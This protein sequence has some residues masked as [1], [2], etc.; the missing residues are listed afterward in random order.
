MKLKIRA[1]E[2]R[3]RRLMAGLSQE[4]LAEKTEGVVSASAISKLE[5]LGG[6]IWPR[7]ARA[8][9]DA[10]KCELPDIVEVVETEEASA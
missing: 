2:L 5:V 8:L 6:G 1:S 4:E 3:R 10:L 9:A 7:T